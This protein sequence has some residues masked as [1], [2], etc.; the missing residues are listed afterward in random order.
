MTPHRCTAVVYLKPDG[1][2]AGRA[3]YYAVP[4]RARRHFDKSNRIH[5]T[6]PNGAPRWR[7]VPMIEQ[8]ESGQ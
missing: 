5:G 4:E 2:E 8:T 3:E 1:S 6:Y 7:L